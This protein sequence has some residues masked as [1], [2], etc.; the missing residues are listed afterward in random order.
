MKILIDLTSLSYHL[1]GIERYALGVTQEMLRQDKNNEYILVFR[2]EVFPE[3]VD[4]IKENG[5]VETVTLH[6]KNKLLFFQIVIPM[7]LY[8]YK[9]DRY[10]FFA[11]P[12]PILFFNKNIYNTI[13]DMGR[14]DFPGKNK[15]LWFYFK[16]TEKIAIKRAKK[17]FTVSE[18]SKER[19]HVNTGID[20]NNI[21]VTYNG[22]SKK[23][24][25]SVSTFENVKKKYN[26]PKRYIMFLS[27]LQPRKNLQLLVEAYSEVMDKV[28]YDLV[29]VGRKGWEVDQ[30]IEKYSVGNRIVFTGFVADEDVA[31]IYKNAI[32]FVFPS[33]YE[34]FGIPPVEAL[35]MGTPV[36]SSDSS[37]MKEILRN[38]AFFFES[39]NKN[40]LKKLLLKLP[41]LTEI[42]PR[43]LDDFMRQNYDYKNSAKIILKAIAN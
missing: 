27:T 32:C 30:L 7:A 23:I 37:C 22:I 26:L 24:S 41:D 31:P 18:F 33:L 19:I 35:A 17:I 38:Q 20:K 14:W 43:E 34:G 4:D 13:H 16:T 25:E 42:M 15:L 6:G 5:R 28:S 29:L 1:S 2:N 36:I 9:A 3:L 10:M 21:I 40:D 11:F 8:K 39:N 12:N